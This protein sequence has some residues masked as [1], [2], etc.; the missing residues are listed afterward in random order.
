[1]PTVGVCEDSV[2][3]L[4]APVTPDWRVVYGREGASEGPGG[5]MARGSEPVRGFRGDKCLP[6]FVALNMGGGGVSRERA[7][8]N[9]KRGETNQAWL[10]KKG[11]VAGRCRA[12]SRPLGAGKHRLFIR[13]ER[14]R[15]RRARRGTSSKGQRR[16]CR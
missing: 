1:M 4:E 8:A 5:W 7:L 2:L 16:Q 3:V 15:G 14:K 9:E 10:P 12:G 6:A 11:R 13:M